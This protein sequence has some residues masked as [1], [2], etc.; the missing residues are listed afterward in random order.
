MIVLLYRVLIYNVKI[1]LLRITGIHSWLDL[2]EAVAN[3]QSSIN[4]HAVRG[5]ID[6]EV[7]EQDIGTEER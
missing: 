1:Y 4:E 3:K 6:L 5:A 2:P 7:A